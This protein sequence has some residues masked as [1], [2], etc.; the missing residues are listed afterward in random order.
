MNIFRED[1]SGGRGDTGPPKTFL[2]LRNI[3]ILKHKC[4]LLAGCFVVVAYIYIFLFFAFLFIY[5][6]RQFRTAIF[7]HTKNSC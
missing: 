4:E 1:K 6:C 7:L 3:W 5:V 2:S